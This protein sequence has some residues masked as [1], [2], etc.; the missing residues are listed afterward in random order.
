MKPLRERAN[1][2]EHILDKGSTLLP[3]MTYLPDSLSTTEYKPSTGKRR[4]EKTATNAKARHWAALIAS[5]FLAAKAGNGFVKR[6]LDTGGV[7]LSLDAILLLHFIVRGTWR[8]LHKM[9]LE[10]ERSNLIG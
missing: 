4:H 5:R 9:F 2:N 1:Y 7:Y 8:N 10:K 6:I 3:S